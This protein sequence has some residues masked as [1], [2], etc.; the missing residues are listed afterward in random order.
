MGRE[1]VLLVVSVY[2]QQ[3]LEIKLRRSFQD[4]KSLHVYNLISDVKAHQPY[5]ITNV[6][7]DVKVLCFESYVCFPNVK[8]IL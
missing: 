7:Q 5:F 6:F 3:E 4:V 1:R 2:N 8:Y